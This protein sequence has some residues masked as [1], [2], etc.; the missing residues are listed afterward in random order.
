MT[1]FEKHSIVFCACIAIMALATYSFTSCDNKNKHD[2]DDLTIKVSENYLMSVYR[3]GYAKGGLSAK[4]T[5]RD[6]INSKDQDNFKFLEQ[7][8][9][10]ESIDTLI[11]ADEI[12]KI[13]T[14]QNS[15]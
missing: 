1:N 12:R 8:E 3:L 10:Y 14:Q 6:M 9:K 11:Y 2:K 7:F 15:H 13:N 5:V 4:K